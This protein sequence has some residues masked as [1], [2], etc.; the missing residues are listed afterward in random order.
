TRRTFLAA[1]PLAPVAL[2]AQTGPKRI[3][4]VDDDLDNYHARVFL[5][6]FRGPLKDR[7]WV[8]A[9]ATALQHDKSRAWAE[10]NALTYYDDPAAL[11][12]HVDAFAVLAPSTPATHEA[13]CAKVL[14]AGKPTFVDKTFAPDAAAAERI[15]AL[16][17]RHGAPIQTSSALRYTAVQAFVAAAGPEA[18]RHV[19]T[20]GPGRSYDEYAIH[21]LELAVSCLGPEALAV[22]RRG[23]GA[24]SQLQIDFSGGRTA[25]VHVC[26]ASKTPYAASVATPKETRYIEVDTKPLFRDAAAAMLGFF[27]ARRAQVDRRE[28]MAILRIL[29]ASRDPAALEGGVKL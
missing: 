6:A 10:R 9:G 21:P 14:P 26:T 2:S 7:G 8:V 27:E 16:A 20:W 13:L 25:V 17:D 5:E 1:L 4:F 15:F 23:T 12:P 28:T 11:A 24:L 19:T 18:V 22:R 29:D 3:G